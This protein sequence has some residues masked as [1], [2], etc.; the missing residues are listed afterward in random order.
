MPRGREAHERR[1]EPD[2]DDISSSRGPQSHS[3]R[4]RPP[5][6]HSR[7][8][9]G[10]RCSAPGPRV[11]CRAKARWASVCKLVE[12]AVRGG[13]SSGRVCS[14]HHP[15]R[16]EWIPAE[17]HPA[18]P[19]T[20]PGAPFD[21]GERHDWIASALCQCPATEHALVGADS[22]ADAAVFRSARAQQR[23]AALSGQR[24]CE[25]TSR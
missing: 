14:R 7:C 17:Q 10:R 24:R 22:R 6:R 16:A 23:A 20:C 12:M 13:G 3:P 18:C 5:T 19:G 21:H 25:E 9:L 4:R 11:L 8:R 2:D 1:E 15:E